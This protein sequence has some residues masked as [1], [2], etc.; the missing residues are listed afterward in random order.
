MRL[1][2]EAG[3]ADML[4]CTRSALRR[5]RLER[6]GPPFVRLG[7]LVRYRQSDL[8]QFIDE[9]VVNRPYSE[10]KKVVD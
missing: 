7:R 2:D 8:E 3:A 4:C 1:I 6:R 10:T 5:W 9:N